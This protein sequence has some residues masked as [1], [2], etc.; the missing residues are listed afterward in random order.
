MTSHEHYLE[1]FTDHLNSQDP[2]IKFITDVEEESKLAFLDICV[3]HRNVGSAPTM[4]YHKA[5]HT[6]EYRN[7]KSN[8]HLQHK[9]SVARTL[10]HRVEELVTTSSDKEA[11]V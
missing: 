8:H 5:T 11:E 9:R 1:G 6:D 2:H 10:L 7:F 4:V 3:H